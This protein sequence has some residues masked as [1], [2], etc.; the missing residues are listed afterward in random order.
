MLDVLV[1]DVL[2]VPFE[3]HRGVVPG[4][5][6]ALA[7]VLSAD[8]TST[9]R[10]SDD[11]AMTIAFADP[12]LRAG[13]LDQD[14][15]ARAFAQHWYD[16]ASARPGVPAR[17]SNGAAMRATPAAL[18]A[19][20][21]AEKAA[22]IA[23]RSARVT[24]PHPGAHAGAAVH[25][26]AVAVALSHPAGAPLDAHRFIATIGAVSDDPALSAGLQAAVELSSHPDAHE[27][28]GRIGTSILASESV[29]AA[30][31]AFLSH[32][33]LFSDA[34]TLAV[35]LGG[36]TD[37]IAAMT[38]ALVGALL[39]E[40]AIPKRWVDRAEAALQVRVLADELFA[41]AQPTARRR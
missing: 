1:G 5:E 10:Y 32:P 17:A 11:T 3:G 9:L 12:L 30:V 16:I 23:R 2:G 33:G 7:L 26:A 25:A 22:E 15:L 8:A 21:N 38:G 28:A 41:Q 31:C 4:N 13:G 37:T 20:G 40:R 29:P 39:G 34:I 6:L 18:Y 27:I 19:A 14:D 36:D 24:H 35:R